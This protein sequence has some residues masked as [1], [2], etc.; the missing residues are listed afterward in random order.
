[1][2]AHV[3]G[4]VF[5]LVTAF[6]PRGLAQTL[7]TLS[8]NPASL[9][10]NYTIGATSLPA[11]QRITIKRSGSGAALNFTVTLPA[12]APWLIVS[13]LQ[14]ATGT[15]VTVQVNPTSLLAGVYTADITVDAAGSAG[16]VAVTATLTIKNPPPVM[17]ATPAALTFNFQTDSAQPPAAQTI[18]VTTNGEPVS[19]SAA[20]SGGTWFAIDANLGIAVSGSPVAITVSILTAGLTPGTYSGKVTLTSTNASNKTVGIPITLTV[21]AGRAVL[22]SIWPSAAPVGSVDPTITIRGQHLFKTSAVQAGATTLASTWISTQVLLAV[23]PQALLATQG[24]LNVTVT[25]SPQPASNALAFTVTPPGPLIQAVTNAAS[26]QAYSSSPDI[27]P[28]EILSIFG[29]GL[30]PSQ[31]LMATP[32]GGFYPSSLGAPATFVQFE[33]APGFWVPAP[34]IFAHA[35]QI[36]C[37]SPFSLPP[38]AGANLRVSY[39]GL[40]SQPYAINV[41]AAEPGLFTTDSSGR[42][43][44][45]ALNYSATTGLYTL[46]SSSSPSAKDSIVILYLTGGGALNPP[47]AGEGQVIPVPAPGGSAPA[48]SAPVSVSMGGEGATVQS[49]TAVPGAIAGLVQLN[50]VVPST[51]TANKAVPVVVTIGGWSSP[52][53]ATIALK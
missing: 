9:A 42:G 50:V 46:N 36:N 19:F 14:G 45:A 53:V 29:S 51:V 2:R 39:N 11:S 15:A 33:V 1:M 12:G 7:P 26:F 10:F 32:S 25:N 34:I 16:P 20:A 30:G 41:V 28:G 52:A 24:N 37:V 47:P 3:L 4:L 27:A 17:T 23:I 5:A 18:A 22:S 35:N 49:A 13:P 44:A 31:L 48:L 38:G 21:T 6:S 40:T 8:A 43:Q